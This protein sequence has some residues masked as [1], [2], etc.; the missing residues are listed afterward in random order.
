MPDVGRS[1]TSDQAPDWRYWQQRQDRL[2][3]A[4]DRIATEYATLDRA[5]PAYVV[6]DELRKIL[7]AN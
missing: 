2:W 7:E 4:I 1:E 5:V 6:V 3:C